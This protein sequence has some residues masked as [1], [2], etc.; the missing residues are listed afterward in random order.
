ML[1][2]RA[3]ERA[4]LTDEEKNDASIALDAYF[5]FLATGTGRE[6]LVARLESAKD[7]RWYPHARL[8]RI[9]PSEENRH[10]WSWVATWDPASHIAK[11]RCPVFL[12]FGDR[13]SDHPT[14]IAV[15]KWR[16]GLKKA[17]NTRVTVMMFPGAGHGIRMREGFSG[18]GRPP[19][20]DGYFESMVGWLWM[21]VVNASDERS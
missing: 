2:N 14:S 10:N 7:S 21:H 9:L 13:D 5:R 16:E 6:E 20:A 4:A 18:S 12:M 19:F 1:P 8:D 17:G 3:F 15:E 11:I